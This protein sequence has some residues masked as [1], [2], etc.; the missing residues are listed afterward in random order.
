MTIEVE[1]LIN[2]LNN[3]LDELQEHLDGVETDIKQLNTLIEELKNEELSD[4]AD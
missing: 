3:R 1:R 2:Q 4:K